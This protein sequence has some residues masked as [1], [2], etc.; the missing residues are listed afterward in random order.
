MYVFANQFMQFNS[1]ALARQTDQNCCFMLSLFLSFSLNQRHMFSVFPPVF[2]SGNFHPARHF[3]LFSTVSQINCPR[4]RKFSEPLNNR[5]NII[6]ECALDVNKK[7]MFDL[8]GA[9]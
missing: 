1:R 8:T 4:L 5:E 7:I 9:L 2:G 6:E 3:L